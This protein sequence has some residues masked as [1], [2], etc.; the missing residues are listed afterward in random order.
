MS[1][2]I[3][4]GYLQYCILGCTEEE[5]TATLQFSSV[6]ATRQATRHWV[7]WFE[8][9]VYCGDPDK[10]EE[11]VDER[12]RIFNAA[13]EVYLGAKYASL[14][15][16]ILNAATEAAT[17]DLAPKDLKSLSG[18]FSELRKHSLSES[19]VRAKGDLDNAGV[20]SVIIKNLTGK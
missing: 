3:G 13:K 10:Y 1:T 11:A 2:D 15:A 7:R 5:L 16:T 19:L 17:A 18:L 9:L 20:P 8:P 4:I 6:A 14:E 12:L